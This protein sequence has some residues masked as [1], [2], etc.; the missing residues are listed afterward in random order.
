M[1]KSSL[2][3]FLT[4]SIIGLTVLSGCS[5]KSTNA[6][7]DAPRSKEVVVYTYDSFVSEWGPGNEIG[8]KFQ[9]ATGYTLTWV[10]CGDG[11]QVLSRALL[12]KDNVQADIILGLDNNIAPKANEAG[13]LEAYKPENADKLIPADVIEVLGK[14]W[15]LTPF[16]YSHFAM[17]YDTQSNVPCPT[18]LEDLTD[19]AYEKKIILM[20]PR[21]STPGLGFVAWTVAIYGDKVLDY[22]KALKPNILTMAPGWSAG[23][24]LFKKGEAPLVIS[25]TTSPASH[26]EYDNTDRYIAPVFEQGHTMQVEGAGLLKGAPNK[27][28]AKAFLDFLISD[29]AQAVIPLTQ[30]MNPVNKN[31]ELPESYKVAAPIP[32]K[33][34]TADPAETDKAVEEI[35]K[36][37]A[38]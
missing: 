32:S 18:S 36:I 4:C 30:W 23:Y 33:T 6:K 11:V 9:E 16:D 3:K 31:V 19:S 21:T 13:I 26:V 15:T 38:D 12:E 14:D 27:E 37:L 2:F 35:M 28:G 34:L 24:G 17:I 5:K 29:Q 20:D 1:N 8:E 7:S 25:Y 10:D 22:W